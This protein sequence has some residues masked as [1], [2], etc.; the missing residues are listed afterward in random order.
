VIPIADHKPKG[1]VEFRQSPAKLVAELPDDGEMRENLDEMMQN[2]GYTGSCAVINTEQEEI[3][4][5]ES[6]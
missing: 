5:N 2:D 1:H 4:G 3:S 6:R